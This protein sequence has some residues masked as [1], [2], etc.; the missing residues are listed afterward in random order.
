LP[1]SGGPEALFIRLYLDRHI[2]PQLAT[3]LRA[4]GYNVLTT[5]EAGMDTAPDE[6]QL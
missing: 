5:Q 6:D 2:K 3:D 1:T 4:E